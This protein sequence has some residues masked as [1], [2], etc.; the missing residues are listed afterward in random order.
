M[1]RSDRTKLGATRRFA[2][3]L[4]LAVAGCAAW[5]LPGAGA[6]GIDEVIEK[7]LKARGGEETLLAVKSLRQ[8]GTLHAGA[9]LEFPFVIERARPNL[10]R[11]DIVQRGTATIRAYDGDVAWGV[12]PTLGIA[13][14]Q[15]LPAREERAL[16]ANADFDGAF[17]R[18][19]E[20]GFELALLEAVDGDSLIRVQVTNAAK[21]VEVFGL[22]PVSYLTAEIRGRRE[23]TGATVSYITSFEDYREVDG[24]QYPHRWSI[25]TDGPAGV[26]LFIVES[27]EVDAEI[28]P[29]RF[30]MPKS[31]GP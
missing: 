17:I 29:A 15:R 12:L 24:I 10:R 27:T 21:H 30:Q 14:P 16:A 26:Q 6:E 4:V 9:N 23:L 28:D 13:E 7:H 25:R 1:K 8:S 3:R 5:A 31:S 2:A 22:D 20:K 19:K 18:P 11:I